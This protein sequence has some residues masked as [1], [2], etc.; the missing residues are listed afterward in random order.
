MGNPSKREQVSTIFKNQHIGIF[1]HYIS[2][3]VNIWK[4][5]FILC[6]N[7]MAYNEYII[8]ASLKLTDYK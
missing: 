2:I 1:S 6:R 3:Y 8:N 7:L 4:Y 5:F